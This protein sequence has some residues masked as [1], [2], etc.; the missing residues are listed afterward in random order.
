MEHVEQIV[1]NKGFDD[2]LI[3]VVLWMQ[4][5]DNQKYVSIPVFTI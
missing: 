3:Q 2:Q 1:L 5:E 4:E